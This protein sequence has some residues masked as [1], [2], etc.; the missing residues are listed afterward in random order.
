MTLGRGTWASRHPALAATCPVSLY[1][2]RGQVW[3]TAGQLERSVTEWFSSGVTLEDC[4]GDPVNELAEEAREHQGCGRAPS[5]CERSQALTERCCGHLIR[6][7]VRAS[8]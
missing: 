8:R 5:V 1:E 3:R 7:H 2:V 6:H 4:E